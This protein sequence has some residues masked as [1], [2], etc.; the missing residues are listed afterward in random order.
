MQQ[1]PNDQY[2]LQESV[3]V[4]PRPTH[5]P[6]SHQRQD[7]LQFN[8]TNSTC[9]NFP[10][11][12]ESNF[13]RRTLNSISWESA[14]NKFVRDGGGDALVFGETKT[15]VKLAKK[16]VKSISEKSSSF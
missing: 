1:P 6:D 13:E 4:K 11:A 3:S 15:M 14:V 7:E 10:P 9:S 8:L 16:K 12:R 5:N 2:L